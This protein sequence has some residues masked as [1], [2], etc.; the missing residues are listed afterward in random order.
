MRSVLW[1]VYG[2]VR[3]VVRPVMWRLRSFLTGPLREE[4]G[5]LRSEVA[6]LREVVE[7][8]RAQ[9]EVS[10]DERV[11]EVMAQALATLALDRER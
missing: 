2:L 3:P 7:R 8:Q 10:A 1:G 6:G 9:A 4:I 5:A 11:R